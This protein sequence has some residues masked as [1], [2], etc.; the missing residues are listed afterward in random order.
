[1]RSVNLSWL[2]L[3]QCVLAAA[4]FAGTSFQT[5]AQ[6]V[7][8]GPTIDYT[9][10][11]PDPTQPEN[12][13]R[14]TGN[15]WLTRGTINGLFNAKSETSFMHYFSPA[16]TEWADGTTDNYASLSYT[17]WNYWVK[18]IHSG[19]PSTIGVSA[20]VHLISDN[21][22]VNITFTSWG[23]NGGGF[24]YVRST[25]AAVNP[26]PTISITN[27]ISGT[28]FAAP[29]NVTIRASASVSSGTVTNV[30]F[31]TNN[32]SLKNVTTAPFTVVANNLAAG[33]YALKAVATAAGISATS[34]PVN[35]SV[36]TPS[37]VNLSAAVLSGG[38]ISFQYSDNAGLSYLVQGSSNLLS[39]VPL[40]TNTP[41]TGSQ[42]FSSPASSPAQYYRIKLLPNP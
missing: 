24:S 6:T 33:A 14:L 3:L 13:D 28:V 8:T 9:Q 25:P 4:F 10:P 21:I 40:A 37:P 1:M 15:V 7:W 23:G 26:P 16:D 12:Q 30:Q 31:F 29:A 41:T 22:Y 2:R 19:P 38:R 18:N 5:H 17:N 35:V 39:W 34:A 20:V 27:P 11:S 36:V 42:T 32:V